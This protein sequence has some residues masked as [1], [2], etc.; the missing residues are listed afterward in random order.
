MSTVFVS[1]ADLGNKENRVDTRLSV[2]HNFDDVQSTASAMAKSGYFL[3]SKDQAQAIV[4]ILA[5]QELGFG[6]FAS[7][8]GVYII[9]GRP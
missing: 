5:G 6:P 3:D 7:M 2:I 9:Q 4:K 8:T 1:N